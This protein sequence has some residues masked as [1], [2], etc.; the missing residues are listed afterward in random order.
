MVCPRNKQRNLVEQTKKV[1]TRRYP[2]SM[3]PEHLHLPFI[4]SSTRP[5]IHPRTCSSVKGP[6]PLTALTVG[7]TFDRQRRLHWEVRG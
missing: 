4:H 7:F 2:I 3:Y 1:F 6:S 5:S